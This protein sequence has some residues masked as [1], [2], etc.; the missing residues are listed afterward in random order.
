VLPLRDLDQPQVGVDGF[1]VHMT[2]KSSSPEAL[3]LM[4]SR[5]SGHAGLARLAE[6]EC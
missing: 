1:L 5:L 4:L 3:P 6:C 2:D